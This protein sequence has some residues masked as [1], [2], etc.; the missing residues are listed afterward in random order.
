MFYVFIFDFALVGLLLC[1]VA[2]FVSCWIGFR[3]DRK[4]QPVYPQSASAQGKAHMRKQM[5]RYA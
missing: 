3:Q 1:A 2:F 4:P 5:K